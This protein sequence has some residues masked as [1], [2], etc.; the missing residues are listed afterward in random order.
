MTYGAV[1]AG[2][3]VAAGSLAFTGDHIASLVV[4]ATGLLFM[5]AALVRAT[6]R[7]GARP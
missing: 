1:S 2:A 5:G 7:R 6:R 3:P 4:L